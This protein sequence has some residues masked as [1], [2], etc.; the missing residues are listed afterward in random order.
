MSVLSILLLVGSVIL[1][2][3]IGGAILF[4]PGIGRNDGRCGEDIKV[5]KARLSRI[6]SGWIDASF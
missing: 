3:I 2:L 1:L 5:S 6:R 4:P